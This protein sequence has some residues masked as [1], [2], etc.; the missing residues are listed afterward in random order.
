M[1][2]KLK[3]KRKIENFLINITEKCYSYPEFYI[4][5]CL[6]MLCSFYISNKI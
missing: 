6:K 5:W 1:Y 4:I 2:K 3:K